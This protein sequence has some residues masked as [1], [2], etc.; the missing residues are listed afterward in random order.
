MR[1]NAA[2][3][4]LTPLYP[5]RAG[6]TTGRCSRNTARRSAATIHPVVQYRASLRCLPPRQCRRHFHPDF[7]RAHHEIPAFC[8]RTVRLVRRLTGTCTTWPGRRPRR[9]RTRRNR[10][11][12]Q[13][14]KAGAD[15]TG[16][17]TQPDRHR[18][19]VATEA[20]ESR[21]EGQTTS[22]LP[23][24]R[25]KNRSTLHSKTGARGP[26]Q[27]RLGSHALRVAREGP[28]GVQGQAG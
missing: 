25:G 3:P 26:M 12:R 10:S 28:R 2:R 5:S 19:E 9:T 14:R 8:C 17:H 24:A 7:P 13:N 23:G 21:Q 22:Q 16:S 11:I 1:S 15:S 27:R 6:R 4:A 18:A 20:G